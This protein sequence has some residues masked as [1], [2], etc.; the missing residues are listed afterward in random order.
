MLK[1]LAGPISPYA[2]KVMVML[3]ETGLINRIEVIV[4]ATGPLLANPIPDQNPLGKIPCLVTED[5]QPIYD[6]R[7]ICAYLDTLHKGAK[8]IPTGETRWRT[9][10]LEATADGML[11]AALLMVYESRLRP[12]D[13][14]F[15]DWVEAQWR[16]IVAALDALETNWIDHLNGPLDLGQIATGTA[17]GYLDLRH[18]ARNWR[19]G[20]P[21]LTAWETKFAKRPSML[22]TAPA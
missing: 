14:Q 22:A 15:A 18:S 5:G 17:L 3:H 13:R 4:T 21:K 20:R 1:L 2:R 10:T 8:L 11:D 16:K 7:V 19:E 12:P 9:L 6:S